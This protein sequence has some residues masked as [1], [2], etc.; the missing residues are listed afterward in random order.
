MG[1]YFLQTLPT[2]LFTPGE[3]LASLTRLRH[4]D[5][6]HAFFF[7]SV[8]F[9]HSELHLL[10]TVF[11][12]LLQ[13]NQR[14]RKTSTSNRDIAIAYFVIF[15]HNWIHSLT[16]AHHSW[17]LWQG[18]RNWQGSQMQNLLKIVSNLKIKPFD[19]LHFVDLHRHSETPSQSVFWSKYSCTR[20]TGRRSAGITYISGV[21]K[22][23][24][25]GLWIFT[26][27]G[28][29]SWL[30]DHC[31]MLLLRAGVGPLPGLEQ[32]PFYSPRC[33]GLSCFPQ[34]QVFTVLSFCFMG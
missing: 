4:P 2:F 22:L 13:E 6:Q 3:G 24:F 17:E 31:C 34:T 28:M 14:N 1:W 7:I 12:I 27:L 32:H 25:F 18:R 19:S 9:G 15:L 20:N 10:S 29:N 30:P 8:V 33:L 5:P 26:S 16:P 11:S 23:S 21:P